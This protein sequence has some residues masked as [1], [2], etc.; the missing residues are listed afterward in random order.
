MTSSRAPQP[1]SDLGKNE[2]GRLRPAMRHYAD[3]D[4]LDAVIIGTG[5]G[6]APLL[7]KLTAAGLRV[8]ALEAGPWFESP[9]SSSPRTSS[10]PGKST[11]RAKASPMAT[12]RRCSAA[13]HPAPAWVAPPCT[14]EHF[15]RGLMSATCAFEPSPASGSTGRSHFAI[16]SRITKNWKSFSASP[17]PARTRGIPR[18]GTPPAPCPSTAP[19]NSCCGATRRLA[20]AP[21]PR[22]SPP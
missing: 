8:V 4:E 5:A 14:G 19:A 12:H 9:P 18:A 21:Q 16:F 20:C 7:A 11:G 3:A 15:A 10:P 13:T 1:Q 2:L 22:Q 6:G 17:V